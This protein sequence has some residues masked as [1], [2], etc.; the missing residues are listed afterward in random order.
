MK[1][2]SKSELEAWDEEKQEYILVDV[3]E[4]WEREVFHIGGSHIPLSELWERKDEIPHEIPVVVYCQKGIRS[5]VAIQR[6]QAIGYD[7][8]YNLSGGIGKKLP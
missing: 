8:L 5:Q 1:N 4:L 3:R 2:I 7:N 6:L